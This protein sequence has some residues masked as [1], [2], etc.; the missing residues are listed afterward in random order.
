MDSNMQE[1]Q[2]LTFKIDDGLYGLDIQA[3]C[4]IKHMQPISA[5]PNVPSYMAG[6]INLRDSIIPIMD[7]RT[8][9][10][11][12]KKGFTKDTCIVVVEW[13]EKRMG[14]IVDAVSTVTNLNDSQIDRSIHEEAKEGFVNGIGKQNDSLIMLMDVKKLFPQQD[15]RI[16]EAA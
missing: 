5:L 2:Y 1:G 11:A 8:R 10:G 9:L 15:L 3:V 7:L 12:P 4:E 14:L 13:S 6:V 16:Q